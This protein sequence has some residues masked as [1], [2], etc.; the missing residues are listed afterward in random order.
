VGF[1]K[2][3]QF[4]QEA[5][6]TVSGAPR[7]RAPDLRFPFGTF[8]TAAEYPDERRHS[9]VPVRILRDRE[10]RNGFSFHL[11]TRS[12]WQARLLSPITPWE[13][14]RAWL[15]HGPR[16]GIQIAKPQY[17]FLRQIGIQRLFG[18]ENL[19][20]AIAK[21]REHSYWAAVVDQFLLENEPAESDQV[22]EH[23]GMAIPV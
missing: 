7:Y 3:K 22:L 5:F 15:S 12:H 14:Q 2:S 23:L 21:L 19:Q 4:R 9:I 11:R 13:S 18:A 8:S 16:G 10:R 1:E 6:S 17:P 20:Q